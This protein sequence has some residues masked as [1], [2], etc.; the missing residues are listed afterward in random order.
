MAAH[1][2]PPTLCA[3]T[4]KKKN[5]DVCEVCMR[6]GQ[7][8]SVSKNKANTHPS[9]LCP[10]DLWKAPGDR[11]HALIQPT[12]CQHVVCSQ[13]QPTP[14]SSG[15]L[16]FKEG[17]F[18]GKLQPHRHTAVGAEPGGFFISHLLLTQHNPVARLWISDVSHRSM[19]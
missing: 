7:E 2:L 9:N 12:I 5:S 18:F 15:H 4:R 11:F 16:T 13:H 10:T 6:L 14:H 19:C 8:I 1:S 3:C 17:T